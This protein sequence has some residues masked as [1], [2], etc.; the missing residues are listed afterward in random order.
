ML[1]DFLVL[2][3]S[4]VT[5]IRKVETPDGMG[6]VTTT[7]TITGLLKAVMYGNTLMGLGQHRWMISDRLTN[8]SSDILLTLP[9]YYS[10]N[11]NDVEIG[12]NSETYKIKGRDNVMGLNE[13]MV[14]GLE[15]YDGN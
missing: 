3:G 6:G 15:K 9:S 11:I 1:E 13:I 12:Y 10:W 2:T 7:T 5:V 4:V 14:V 8:I